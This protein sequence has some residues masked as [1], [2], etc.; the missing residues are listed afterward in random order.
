[1]KKRPPL[2]PL[3]KNLQ[4]ETGSC[5]QKFFG[6]GCG[7]NLFSKK[8]FPRKIIADLSYSVIFKDVVHVLVTTSGEVDED[9]AV[10]HSLCKLHTECNCVR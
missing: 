10:I 3:P 2:K 6:K 8:G 9:R 7:G 4:T 5:F 1:M